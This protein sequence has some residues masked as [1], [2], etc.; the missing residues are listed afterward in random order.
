MIFDH[1]H[2]R[3]REIAGALHDAGIGSRDGV[4]E[5]AKQP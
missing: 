2:H 4:G 5:G 3:H 1:H